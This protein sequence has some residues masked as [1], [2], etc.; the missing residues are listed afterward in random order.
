MVTPGP[1]LG[2]LQP[3]AAGARALL[4]GH[5]GHGDHLAELTG[6]ARRRA[7]GRRMWR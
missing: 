7:R 1:G 5:G 2:R 3:T 6:I 4:V